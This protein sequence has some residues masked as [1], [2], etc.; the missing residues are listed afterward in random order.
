MNAV[1]SC[2]EPTPVVLR[3][4]SSVVV[5]RRGGDTVVT[6][7]HAAHSVVVTRGVPG[8]VGPAGPPGGGAGATYTHTQST[9]LAVWTIAHNLG[10]RP[11]IT[12]TDHLGRRIEPDV[13]YLDSELAQVTHSVPLTGFAYCN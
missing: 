2:H 3:R 13:D 12:V 10:R 4:E 5:T 6:Q 7:Q 11:S 9:A 1:A 8:P